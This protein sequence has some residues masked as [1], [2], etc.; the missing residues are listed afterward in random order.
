MANDAS[1]RQPYSGHTFVGN[2]IFFSVSLFS[3]I[4]RSF[5]DNT[6]LIPM[7]YWHL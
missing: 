5:V 2:P 1:K 4:S 7:S 6:V 3:K